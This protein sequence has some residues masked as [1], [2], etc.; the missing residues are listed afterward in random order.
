M[1]YLPVTRKPKYTTEQ[2]VA[3]L[4]DSKGAV[5]VAAERLGCDPD[6]IY[7][8]VRRSKLVARVL[9]TERGKVID[10][11]ELKLYT[12]VLNGEPWAIAMVLKTIG[13]DRGYYERTEHSGREDE[14]VRHLTQVVVRDRL[15]AR[16]FF[17][18]MDARSE[19]NGHAD[20]P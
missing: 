13:K 12:A 16:E 4:K 2:I 11:A 8:R 7:R 1:R 3:A 15:E 14:P 5:Y 19:R 20:L 17:A 10:S 6:T 18:R 9:E